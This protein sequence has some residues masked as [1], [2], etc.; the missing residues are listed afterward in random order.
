[1]TKTLITLLAGGLLAVAPALASADS[2]S[3]AENS[4]W[5]G[6]Y[7]GAQFGFDESS[8]DQVDS[9]A[10]ISGGVLGGYNG[11]VATG[12]TT[13]P[14]IVG[15][16]LFAEF[17]GQASHNHNVNYGSNTV[18]VDALAGY[19][20]GIN[21]KLLPYVKVGLADVSGTGD[22]GGNDIGPRIG[23]GVGYHFAPHL[24][25]AAQWMHQ[26]ADHITNDVFTLGL[27]YQFSM[28]Q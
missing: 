7:L 19:P 14:I 6:P 11:A 28:V 15:G 18:G 2:Y 10:S 24:V 25:A 22:R 5:V 16:D 20:L 3:N 27:N 8:A 17:N 12:D 23:V 21:R 9:Q 26:S 13:A 1:M 4:Q